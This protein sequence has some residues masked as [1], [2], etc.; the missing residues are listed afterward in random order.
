M[1]C[2][3]VQGVNTAAGI[4]QFSL[5]KPMFREVNNRRYLAATTTR[6]TF[7]HVTR[8][9]VETAENVQLFNARAVCTFDGMYLL[10][11]SKNNYDS[12]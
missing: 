9:Q 6:R 7:N 12:T 10:S 4:V 5:M 1:K 8:S 3:S 11:N 2:F